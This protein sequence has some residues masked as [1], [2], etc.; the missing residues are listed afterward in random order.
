MEAEATA[1]VYAYVGSGGFLFANIVETYGP[2]LAGAGLLPAEALE[3]W[4]AWQVTQARPAGPIKPSL[5]P[6]NYYTYLTA[7]ARQRHRPDLGV[8]MGSDPGATARPNVE[9]PRKPTRR[10]EQYPGPFGN[11]M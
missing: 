2:N 1:H 11:R 3:R 10:P 5:A 9:A 8:H 7:A 4:R 6:S